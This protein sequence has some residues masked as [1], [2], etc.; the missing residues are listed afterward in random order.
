MLTSALRM[1]EGEAKDDTRHLPKDIR[2]GLD[3]VR[4]IHD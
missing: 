1:Q 2:S 4:L 3:R